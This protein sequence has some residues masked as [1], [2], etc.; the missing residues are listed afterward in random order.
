MLMH[1]AEG[2]PAA[3]PATAGFGIGEIAR[4]QCQLAGFAGRTLAHMRAAPRPVAGTVYERR[5]SIV[6][7]FGMKMH[8]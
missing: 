6:R 8:A 1:V 7:I 5:T 4:G 2:P 3:T